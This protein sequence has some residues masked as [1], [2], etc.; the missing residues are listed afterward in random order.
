[1]IL[2]LEGEGRRVA[3]P[4]QLAKILLAAGGNFGMDEVRQPRE[5]PIQVFPRLLHD[6]FGGGHGL[7]QLAPFGSVGLALL[8][9]EL[10]FA[11]RLVLVATPVEL[12]DLG[13]GRGHAFLGRDCGLDVRVDAA[14]AAALDDFVAPG[15]EGARIQHVA[16]EAQRPGASQRRASAEPAPSQRRAGDLPCW[17]RDQLRGGAPSSEG[18]RN[19]I[20]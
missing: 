16:R 19:A 17:A 7:L 2:G 9:R 6:C 20:A 12:V 5:M 4:P 10:A 18:T 8:G 11:T 3:H 1:M 13:L 14:A 15:C